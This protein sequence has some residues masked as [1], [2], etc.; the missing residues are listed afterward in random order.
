MT[1]FGRAPMATFL[2]SSALSRILKRLFQPV[3]IEAFEI[4]LEVMH[5]RIPRRAS[6]DFKQ[7]AAARA[8]EF[9]YFHPLGIGYI[10]VRID[11]PQRCLVVADMDI[12]RELPVLAVIA[13]FMT[14]FAFGDAA[15]ATLYNE[16]VIAD[17]EKNARP[18]CDTLLQHIDEFEEPVLVLIGA[19]DAFGLVP[20]QRPRSEVTDDIL[21]VARHELASSHS[22]VKFGLRLQKSR[23]DL[24]KRGE[25][26]AALAYIFTTSG[27]NAPFTT[28]A[29]SFF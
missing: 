12:R 9:S 18:P 22:K 17:R 3:V 7:R 6:F 26:F 10:A 1:I 13:E 4:G 14:A 25:S 2:S 27:A 23:K 28:R 29:L 15:L 20:R 21:A 11:L 16:Q 8:D 19:H 5:D 24:A